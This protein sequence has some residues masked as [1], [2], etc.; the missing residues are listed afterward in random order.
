MLV[1]TLDSLPTVRDPLPGPIS[2]TALR[3]V[4]GF[5]DSQQADESSCELS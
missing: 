5:S 4:H 2:I 1:P 3:L